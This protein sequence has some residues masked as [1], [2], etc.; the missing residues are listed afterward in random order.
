M[1][2]SEREGR[3]TR[4]TD[5][6]SV[7][8]AA[9]ALVAV[10]ALM[11]GE[12]LIAG[13]AAAVA[14]GGALQARR[15][16]QRQPAPMP[17]SM[18]W[19]LYLPRWP[20]TPAR[21]RAILQPR[22]GERVLELGPGVGIYALPIAAALAPHG[23]LDVLDIQPEMLA[24]L[25]RRAAAARVTGIVPATGDAQRLPYPDASFDAAY[26]IG[27]L[28]EI[29]DPAAALHELRRVLRPDGR[30]VVGEV[31]LLDPD[32]MRLAAL[33]RLAVAA[34]FALESRLGP[35]LAY[36]ARLRPAPGTAGRASERSRSQDRPP[37]SPRNGPAA[38]DA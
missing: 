33:S 16:S 13:V 1:V 34:G 21:L 28:G 3:P 26:L 17:Y 36:F 12:G 20:L 9:A 31:L 5:W 38:V 4:R 18:R 10:A 29:P 35:R 19:V 37:G 2:Q 14:A 6:I 27:V 32:G 24:V 15:A 23:R 11:A 22:P 7:A 30:L 25:A 8:A